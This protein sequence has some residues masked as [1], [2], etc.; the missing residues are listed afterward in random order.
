MRPEFISA[1]YFEGRILLFEKHGDV[2]EFSPRFMQWTVLA[3]S[4]WPERRPNGMI[5]ETDKVTFHETTPEAK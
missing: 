1:M 2:Y 3:H 5:P 4:P